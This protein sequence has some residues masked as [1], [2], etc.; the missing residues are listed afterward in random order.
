MGPKQHLLWAAPAGL[1]AAGGVWALRTFDPNV[2]GNPF[3]GCVFHAL[4]GLYCPACGSTRAMHALVHFDLPTALSMN[5]L[6]L[7]GG[8]L[9][10]LLVLRA[11]EK[12]P[13]ALEPWLR[14]LAKP[15]LWVG[16][17]AGFGIVRNLPWAPF[18]WLAPGGLA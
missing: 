1:L 8:P 7:I 14:P 18:S 6:L 4:T 13:A 3:P 2:A 16:I 5:A 12:T 9:G 11:L 10:V 15:W 17:V